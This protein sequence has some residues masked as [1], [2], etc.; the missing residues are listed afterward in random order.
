MV[1]IWGKTYVFLLAFFL[2]R[3]YVFIFYKIS[4]I[5][6]SSS[7]K[8]YWCCGSCSMSVS[9]FL[10]LPLRVLLLLV[11]SGVFSSKWFLTIKYSQLSP[12]LWRWNLIKKFTNPWW[13]IM[14]S[15]NWIFL[16]ILTDIFLRL[17]NGKYGRFIWCYSRKFINNLMW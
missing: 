17:F 13:Y 15:I 4:T 10:F 5:G 14:L 11:C 12:M 7:E 16:W 8:S 6:R 1:F 2:L 3:L 9:I